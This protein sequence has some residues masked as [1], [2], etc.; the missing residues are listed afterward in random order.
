MS[1]LVIHD[2]EQGG[3]EW[4]AARAGIPTAS[5]FH[6]VLAKGRDGGA[7][8]TRKQYLYQLAGEVVTG[9]VAEG[10]TNA[11]MERGKVMEAEARDLYEFLVDEPLSRVGFMRDDDK[12]AGCSPDSLVGDTGMLEIK[13]K[14][15]ARAIE[16]MLR[17]DFP[18]EHKAQCQGALWISDRIWIDLAIYWP[19]LPL[20]RYRAYRDEDYCHSLAKAIKTFNDE[21]DEIVEKVRRYGQ[22]S[23]LKRDLLLSM[24]EATC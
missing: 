16:A 6:T 23:T 8:V 9:A 12:R 1:S 2:M 13:T 20:I 10:Y 18:P 7:S 17:G 5:E 21:L 11:H 15:P 19:G 22:P 14:L 4:F 24:A 3:P